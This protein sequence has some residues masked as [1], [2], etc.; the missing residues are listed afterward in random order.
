M[1]IKEVT[2]NPFSCIDAGKKFIP[3]MNVITDVQRELLDGLLHHRDRYDLLCLIGESGMGRTHT[4]K[5]IMDVISKRGFNSDSTV[6][7]YTN[8]SYLTLRS[9]LDRLYPGISENVSGKMLENDD[10]SYLIFADYPLRT[11]NQDLEVT[12]KILAKLSGYEN[13]SVVFSLT[14]SQMVSLEEN[15]IPPERYQSFGLMPLRKEEVSMIIRKRMI[16]GSEIINKSAFGS[17]VGNRIGSFPSIRVARNIEITRESLEYIH[18]ISGGNPRL[19]LITAQTLYDKAREN[20][21]IVIDDALIRLVSAQNGYS[22]EGNGCVLRSGLS[23]LMEVILD[24]FTNKGVLE[25][26]ILSYMAEKF[27]WDFNITRLRLRTLVKM[28]LLFDELCPREG[29]FRQYSV[30]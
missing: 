2:V 25:H 8:E 1:L 5:V 21:C 11:V 29:W 14:D 19:A 30:R 26:N 13:I 22:L 17:S 15:S 6:M 9:F 16:P 18:G 12:A 7:L 27:D 28:K 4:Q 20:N 10:R 23:K 3:E 24:K